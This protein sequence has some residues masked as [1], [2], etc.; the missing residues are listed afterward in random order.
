H[1]VIR[2]GAAYLPLDLTLPHDR[3][4]YMADTAQPVC[5]LT[6]LESLNA[7]PDDLNGAD[8]VVLDSPEIQ[9]ELAG[10]PGNTVTDDERTTPLHPHHP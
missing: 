8:P 7:L 6:D 3:L 2:A 10:L 9:A 4:T 5:V 1:A